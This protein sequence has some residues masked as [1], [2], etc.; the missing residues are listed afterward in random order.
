MRTTHRLLAL[1]GTW[2]VPR[3]GLMFRKTEDGFALTA[4]MPHE[5]G[6]DVTAEQLRAYQQEDYELIRKQGELA[7]LT[8]TNEVG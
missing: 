2:G 5:P 7:G 1:G 4:M 3:S 8:M 6:M